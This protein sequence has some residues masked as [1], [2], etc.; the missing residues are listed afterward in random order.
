MSKFL[1]IL[2][3]F[4]LSFRY[5]ESEMV[6]RRKH[7]A[8]KKSVSRKK[9]KKTE[10]KIDISEMV[11]R[12]VIAMIFVGI[13]ALLI[14]SLFEP[15]GV[16]G[17]GFHTLLFSLFGIGAWFLPLLF[18]AISISLFFAK[19]V[20]FSF[21]KILG[22]ILLFTSLLGIIH[23]QTPI[24]NMGEDVHLYGGWV[25]FT[26]SV[27]LRIMFSSESGDVAVFIILG[28]MFLI[29]IMITFN[30]SLRNLFLFLFYG[31]KPSE[32]PLADNKKK[33]GTISVIAPH[34]ES[35][36]GVT[37]PKKIAAT[38]RDSNEIT[39]RKPSDVKKKKPQGIQIKDSRVQNWK[40][41][42]LELLNAETSEMY[43]KEDVLREKAELIRKT[44]FHFG[45]EPKMSD[46]HVGPTVTQ[47]TLEPP[48]GVKLTKITALKH[49]LALSLAARS[50]RIEAPIPGKALVGIEIPNENRATVRM[51]EIMESDEFASIHSSLRLPLGRDVSGKPICTDLAA[52]PHLLIAGSTG[53]GKSVGMN[54]FITSLLYQNA[55]QDLK[56]IMI[57]P[58]RVELTT[59]NGIPHLLTPVITE[60]DK[61]LAALRWAVAEMMRRYEECSQKGYRNI[62]EYNESEEK[63]LPK[64]III[65]DE[66]ADLMMREFKKDTEAAICRLAQMA[67]AVGMHLIIAT[68]RPSVDVI[69]GLI[70]ANI[71]SRISFTVTSSIDSR[72]ILDSVGAEDLLGMGDML[73]ITPALSK[74]QRIQGIYLSSAEIEKV[75]NS[76][77]LSVVE[78]SEEDESMETV[79]FSFEEKRLPGNGLTGNL[80]FSEDEGSNSN[81]GDALLEQATEV[82]RETGKASATLL[83][84]RL[85]I[86]YA[87]AAKILDLLEEQGIVGP[88][89]G[90]KPRQ[91]YIEDA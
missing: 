13:S 14:F 82:I 32:E 39:I 57:D 6:I 72:T 24:T 10:Y 35:D 18:G 28:I 34:Y 15:A 53:S 20:L 45:I 25:G 49:D 48:S 9:T 44:L 62:Q 74:P 17:K 71:P 37:S 2:V 61:A 29:G 55:P 47:F 51:K 42:S 87:R 75:T 12:E 23:L 54:T 59:Y 43:E 70:K 22:I 41:P 64:L 88:A 40:P 46:I 1:R 69:T 65:I 3:P 30:L 56:C 80:G 8:R 38:V 77:K 19:N 67:R 26:V 58:K 66:L 4:S 36:G 90:A 27:L 33:D 16:L 89:Q 73:F 52:M 76:I 63:K 5:Y 91:V 31:P 85:S 50:V 11:S 78:D 83:Q 7:S 81:G 79:E 68:Q 21:T 86:G 84:R 60:A